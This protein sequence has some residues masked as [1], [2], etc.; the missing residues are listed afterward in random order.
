MDLKKQKNRKKNHRSCK[1][2]FVVLVIRRWPNGQ[3]IVIAIHRLSL[4]IYFS[5][6]QMRYGSGEG[7]FL[8]YGGPFLEEVFLQKTRC[9]IKDYMKSCR[10]MRAVVLREFV[11]VETYRCHLAVC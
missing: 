4:K 10:R 9:T 1:S 8:I 5:N 6:C 2:A 7:G 11:I 3:I